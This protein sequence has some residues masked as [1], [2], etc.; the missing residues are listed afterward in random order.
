MAWISTET[1]LQND[2]VVLEP[3]QARD[4]DELREVALEPEIW[5]HFVFRI[6]DERDLQSFVDAALADM[7]AE[8]RL[9]FTIRDAAQGRIAGSMAFGNLAHADRR[10]ELGWSW[11]GKPFRGTRIN[12]ASKLLM[13]EH[14]FTALECERVEFKTDELNV[15]ARAGLRKIGAV[16]EGTLRSYNFMPSGRRR[17]AVFYSIL[18]AEWPQVKQRLSEHL[19]GAGR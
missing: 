8:R 14:A 3:M 9:V 10:L 13:L 2:I 1:V 12:T 11:L 7:S 17:D 16:E 6:D 4:L 18:R 5:E 19:A 15:R